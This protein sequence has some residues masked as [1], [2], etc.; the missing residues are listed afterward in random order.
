M[1]KAGL[2]RIRQSVKEVEFEEGGDRRWWWLDLG[3]VVR[4]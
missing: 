3:R 4:H 2:V 1:G